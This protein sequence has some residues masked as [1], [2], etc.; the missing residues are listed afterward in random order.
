M[1]HEPGA[2]LDYYR[3]RWSGEKVF[4][5]VTPSYYVEERDM[6]ARMRDAHS[7]VRFLL[8]MRNPIDRLWSGLR[9]TRMG[10]PQ[11]DPPAWL[12]QL[13][14]ASVPPWRR[15]YVT[16]LSDLDT[17]VPKDH[18]KVCFFEDMF[19]MTAIADLCAFLG[20]ETQ[21][22]NVGSVTN[23]SEGAGLDAERRGRLYAK[24]EPVYRFIH[25]RYN[26]RLPDSW[27]EDMDRFGVR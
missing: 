11:F 3:K 9:L 23:Q 14:R 22:A 1:N 13:L 12:D 8:V 20:V 17:V 26:G 24:L 4:A 21:P 7:T 5:D 15:N 25:E 19:D 10:N 6:F 18:L 16:A 2:F 27:L